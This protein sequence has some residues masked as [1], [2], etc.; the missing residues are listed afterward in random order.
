MG[1]HTSD[2]TVRA[3]VCS[4]LPKHMLFIFSVSFKGPS[5]QPAIG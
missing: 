3:K 5:E 4:L 2:S 1:K